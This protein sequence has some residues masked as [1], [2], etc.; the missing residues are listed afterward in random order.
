AEST[1][2]ERVA[3][4][5]RAR[6]RRTASDAADSIAGALRVQDS[7]TLAR[8]LQPFMDDQTVTAISVT[9]RAGAI[10]FHWSRPPQAS[11]AGV[12]REEASSPV[13]EMEIGRASCRGGG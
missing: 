12:L 4:E 11:A 3:L 7:A 10:V 8:R 6:A 13:R 5:L 2:R 9:D 1:A